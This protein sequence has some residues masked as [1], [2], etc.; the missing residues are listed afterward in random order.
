MRKSI[1]DTLFPKTRAKVLTSVHLKP[2]YWWYLSDLA[3]HL[4]VTVSSLQREMAS[5]LSSGILESKRNG[6]RVYYR[7]NK[8]CP[9]FQE[10]QGL[11]VKTSGIRDIIYDLLSKHVKQIKFAFIYGSIARGEEISK[12]D[13]DVMVIGDVSLA[14]FG[15]KLSKV[16]DRLK[17]EVNPTIYS[18][19]DFKK[20]I[21]DNHFLKEVVRDKK[22]FIIGSDEKFKALVE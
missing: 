20:K 2:D 1:I 8:T 12:S 14:D 17:R 11:F 4:E 9:V 18:E 13:V 6:N 15:K 5:L 7:A 21:K 10:L 19:A 22:I 16:E 3:N